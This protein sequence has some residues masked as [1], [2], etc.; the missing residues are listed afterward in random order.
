MFDSSC[1]RG[2][3]HFEDDGTQN[4]L[5]LQPVFNT[6]RVIERKLKG[7][8]DESIKPLS[9]F[10]N[11]LNPQISYFDNSRIEIKFDGYCLKQDKVTKS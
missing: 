8:S 2:K 11:S 7:L 4:Y 1:F 6:S 9:T 3:S 10:D 5:V